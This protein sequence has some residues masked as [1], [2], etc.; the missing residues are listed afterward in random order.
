[1][2][3]AEIR[4]AGGGWAKTAALEEALVGGFIEDLAE[5]GEGELE[6]RGTLRSQ[7]HQKG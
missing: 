1:V 5:G 6:G 2:L 3:G 7:Q 4:I